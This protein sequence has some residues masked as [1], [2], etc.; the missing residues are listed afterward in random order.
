[1]EESGEWDELDE[2]YFLPEEKT[3]AQVIDITEKAKQKKKVQDLV[4][5]LIS[6]DIDL[7]EL[8]AFLKKKGSR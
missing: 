2:E 3:K 1:M 8:E 4:E 6:S 5:K 7:D